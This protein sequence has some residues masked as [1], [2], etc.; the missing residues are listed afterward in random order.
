M[1]QVCCLALYPASPRPTHKRPC[2]TKQIVA[3]GI[4][5][6]LIIL[7]GGRMAIGTVV[8]AGEWYFFVQAIGVVETTTVAA[9]II[10]ALMSLLVS[11]FS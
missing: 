9:A 8:S 6:V 7:Y 3:N 4:G 2:K 11:A 10:A 1:E 5:T